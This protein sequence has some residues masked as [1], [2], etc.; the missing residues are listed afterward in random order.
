MF[1]L[2]VVILRRKTCKNNYYRR[3]YCL[4]LVKAIFMDVYFLSDNALLSMVGEKVKKRRISARLT[5]RQVAERAHVALSAIGNIENGRSCAMVTMVQVLR[6]LNALDLLE[7]FYR[8][9][10][11]SPRAVAQYEKKRPARQR[12]RNKS[13][14]INPESEW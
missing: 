3:I 8:E 6:A 4:K 14:E 11:I 9:E 13:T 10:P 7:P 12:V 5:Q 1:Q 2:F